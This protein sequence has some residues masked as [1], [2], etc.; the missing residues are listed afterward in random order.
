MAEYFG[1]FN[2][3]KDS[4]GNYDRTYK[5][6]DYCDNLA[7]IISNGVLRSDADDLKP[8]ANGVVVTIAPGRAWINGH[9]YHLDTNYTFSVDT[10]STGFN[11]WDRVVLRLDNNLDKRSVQLAY[12]TGAGAASPTKP[13]LTRNN[14]VWEICIC[15][16]YVPANAT[17]VT[18]TDTRA[19]NDVCGWVYSTSGDDSFFTSLD[20]QFDVWFTDKKD[21][22]STSTVEIEYKQYTV[23][24]SES[25]TVQITIPQ[26]DT[27]YDQ[28]I[29]VYVNGMLESSP[30]NYSISGN[31]ITFTNSLIAGTEII[32]SIMVAK[33]GTGIPSVV[34]DVT[35]LQDRVSALETGFAEST[36]TYICNGVDDNVKISDIVTTYLNGGTDYNSLRINVYGN[37]VASAPV[38]GDGS[39]TSMYRWFNAGMGSAVNRKVILDFAGCSQISLNCSSGYNYIVFFGMQCDIRNANVVANG[40]GANIHMFSQSGTTTVNAENSRFWIT[41]NT[42]SFAMSGRFVN[43]RCSLTLTSG[44][45]YMFTPTNNSLIRLFGGEYYAYAPTG[46]LSAVVYVPSG[47]TSACVLT[48]GINCP[49]VSRSGYVQSYSIQC[50]SES[51]TCSFTDTIST[52]PYAAAQQNNRGYINL[53]KSGLM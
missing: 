25:T 30:E 12:L 53:S 46:N 51:G 1:F 31:V 18:V 44:N 6:E 39:S 5:S 48:Y 20:N 36:Y 34:G 33:D 38:S 8:S 4:E 35:D 26:Y 23:L 50:L 32:V 24:E 21:T 29:H 15:D 2:A 37:F 13:T 9:W 41:A 47:Y 22:L 49:Q 43:C 10:A 52:L 17:S 27:T 11:R 45:A 3:L 19:D 42:G 28:K 7:V 16:V 40:S 14:S